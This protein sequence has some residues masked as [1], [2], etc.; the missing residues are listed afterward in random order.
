MKKIVAI[1]LAMVMVMGLATT[2]FAA[3]GGAT[4]DTA[5]VNYDWDFVVTAEDAEDAKDATFATYT[6]EAT[7]KKD[8]VSAFWATLSDVEK[9]DKE[10]VEINGE[11]E[12]VKVAAGMPYDVAIVDGKTVSYYAVAE[13]YNEDGFV[14]KATK[15][16]LPVAPI[17]GGDVKCNTL[18]ADSALTATYY[19]F[20]GVTCLFCYNKRH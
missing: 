20:D 11:D 14:G 8:G 1:V 3:K 13:T 17:D 19:F 7:A 12:F 18:Y 5:K 2:A 9:G 10:D 15:V 4:F 16:T 6:I